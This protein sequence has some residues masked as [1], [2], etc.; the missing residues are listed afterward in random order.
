ME[1]GEVWLVLL[2]VTTLTKTIE[3]NDFERWFENLSHPETD[4]F[5]EKKIESKKSLSLLEFTC[6]CVS[7]NV[8]LNYEVTNESGQ[9]LKKLTHNG[10]VVI[11][12]GKGN[13][14]FKFK[15]CLE[16]GM[17]NLSSVTG[18]L[19]NDNLEVCFDTACTKLQSLHFFTDTAIVMKR[20]FLYSFQA[21]VNHIF[22]SN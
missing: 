22:L 4:C 18:Y 12:I 9:K 14:G 13:F 16:L 3:I 20:E 7:E 17:P 21:S 6:D 5:D 19:I 15:K 8:I 10:K 11:V 2:L 1:L